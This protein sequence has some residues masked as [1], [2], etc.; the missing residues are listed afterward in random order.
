MQRNSIE[1]EVI[2][3]VADALEADPS[4]ITENASLI[5]DLEGESIDFLDIRYRLESVFGIS[6]EDEELWQGRLLREHAHLVDPKKGI[7]AESLE[8]LRKAMPDFDWN[9]FPNGVP[10]DD[11]PRLI[12]IRTIIDY[13]EERLS[14][15]QGEGSK[16]SAL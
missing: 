6:I 15:G 7:S 4:Q 5:D 12:T 1:R 10:I 16:G 2:A 3:I 13:L 14:D 9:R 11:L 8:H